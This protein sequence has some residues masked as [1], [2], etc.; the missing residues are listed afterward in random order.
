MSGR[1]VGRPRRT[2]GRTVSRTMVILGDGASEKRYFDE[3]FRKRDMPVKLV[4][5][6]TGE[7]GIKKNVRK[8]MNVVKELGL[9]LDEGDRVAIVTDLDDR[10][11]A[12][13]LRAEVDECLR[14]GF[15]L[16]LS[17]PCFEVWLLLHYGTNIKK[18]PAS[19]MTEQLQHATGGRYNKS[20][21]ISPSPEMISK[22]IL[23]AE[24]LQGKNDLAPIRCLDTN[25][26]T[27]VNSLVRKINGS[28]L[29]SG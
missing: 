9:N 18:G 10:Y 5:R 20:K 19:F 27:M 22:A 17:N 6:E 21:G 11:D 4:V 2:G 24:R 26:S 25:P 8:G 13:T 14:R 15:E 16:Y 28:V 7:T 29:K 23:N 3:N 1:A 12:D